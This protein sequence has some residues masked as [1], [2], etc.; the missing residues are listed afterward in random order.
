MIQ[1]RIPEV[2]CLTFIIIRYNR[3]YYKDKILKKKY[4]KICT[5]AYK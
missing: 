2:A 1:R 5:Y 3:Y 4:L